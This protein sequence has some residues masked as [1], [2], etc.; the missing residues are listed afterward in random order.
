MPS[1]ISITRAGRIFFLVNGHVYPQVDSVPLISKYREPKLL[2]MNQHNGQFKDVSKSAGEALQIPQVSRGV[3]AGD[4]FNDGRIDLV[5]ENLEGQPMIL[6]PEGTPRNHWISLELAGVKS[7][8]LGL[9]AQVKVIAGSLAQTDEVR[10]GGSYMS[11]SDLRLHFGLADH[12]QADK[13]EIIWPSGEKEILT[14]LAADRYYC[15][16]EGEGAVACSKIRPATPTKTGK[17]E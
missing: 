13:V 14:N 4:L 3:A 12:A 1:S 8:K 15:L 9:N 5:V 17:L 11:Q 6:R 7:N 10:S 16:E 2:F